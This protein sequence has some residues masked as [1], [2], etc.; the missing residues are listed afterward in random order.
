MNLEK[1]LNK[2][3]SSIILNTLE[4]TCQ[5]LLSEDVTQNVLYTFD[6]DFDHISKH[7]YLDIKNK[8]EQST[9]KE[10]SYI[11]N[12][13]MHS[14]EYKTKLFINDISCIIFCKNGLPLVN[15]KNS[16]HINVKKCLVLDINTLHEKLAVHYNNIKKRNDKL[17]RYYVTTTLQ[18]IS[19][20]S[21]ITTIAIL[22]R[23]Q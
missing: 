13:I 12:L 3:E 22:F 19:T 11:Y 18:T 15:V 5:Y 8:N 20:V 1:L 10:V 17:F 23:K 14:C 9:L 16:Q 7:Q 6:R 21:L 2:L 4:L